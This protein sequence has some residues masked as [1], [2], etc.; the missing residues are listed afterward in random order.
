MTTVAARSAMPKSRQL[1]VVSRPKHGFVVGDGWAGIPSQPTKEEAQLDRFDAHNRPRIRRCLILA[2]LAQRS[3]ATKFVAPTGPEADL[4]IYRSVHSSGLVDFLSTAEK[5]WRD[6]GE[7]G[8]DVICCIPVPSDASEELARVPPLIP[9]FSPLPRIHYLKPGKNV[10]GKIGYYCTDR[11]TPIVTSLFDELCW[12]G[13]VVRTA[14]EKAVSG[15]S[16][17][18]YAV[19]IHPG[20]HAANDS[21]GGYC[22]V[23][24]AAMA[25]RLFQ[26]QLSARSPTRAKPKVAILDVDYHCGDGTA[27]IFYSDPSVLLVSIH[28][29]PEQDYPFTSGYA[30]QVGSDG[31]EGT[32]LHLPLSPGTTWDGNYEV[33]LKKALA[34]IDDFGA[35]A[36]VVSLGLDTHAGDGISTA[37]AGFHLNCAYDDYCKMGRTIGSGVKK[38]VPILFIQEGGYEMDVVARAASDVV[39]SS[40]ID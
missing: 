29:D 16:R 8:R 20:H 22:Y 25:A 30:D 6:L 3:E 11:F 21:F 1:L 9:C 37:R 12:D 40:L 38:E 32:T 5:E 13:A 35:E 23:N 7:K 28:C 26:A 27:S 34:A 33:A 39:T 24:H 2:E 18:V 14:V 17:V 19:T 36:L 15:E 4:S 31:A 10:M